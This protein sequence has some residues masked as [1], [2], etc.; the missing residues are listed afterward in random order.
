MNKLKCIAIDDE[1]LALKQLAAYINDVPFLE[2]A[3]Q[4]TSAVKAYDLLDEETIDLMFVDVNMPDLNGLDFVK[5]LSQKPLLIFTTAYSE[6][7][8][9]G[10]K[11]NAIDYLLKPFSFAEFSGAAQK[12]LT[13]FELLNGVKK[14]DEQFDSNDDYLFIKSEYKL[15]R[16]NLDDI[17]FIEGMREYVRI[18]QVD[19]KPVMTLM[20]MKALEEKLS[21]AKFMR[22]HRSYIVNL[23]RVRIVE[24]YRI[25]FDDKTIIPVSDNYKEKFQEFLDQSFMG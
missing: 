14:N 16:I 9:E 24:R 13:Q 23:E 25:I 12:A 8:V 15:I 3:G 18:H 19:Q 20:S 22:I 7:A 17:Q 10:F 1:P 4:F 2:L 11:V 6:Y 5:T 21:P